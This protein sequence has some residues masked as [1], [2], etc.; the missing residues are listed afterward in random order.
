M[1]AQQQVI[2]LIVVFAIQKAYAGVQARVVPGIFIAHVKVW[3]DKHLSSF[4]EAIVDL[5][6]P[7]AGRLILQVMPLRH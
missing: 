6:M 4:F 2:S 1:R 7:S 3:L 5:K